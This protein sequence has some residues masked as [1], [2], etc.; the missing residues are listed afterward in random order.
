MPAEIEAFYSNMARRYESSKMYISM[1]Y[2]ARRLGDKGLQTKAIENEAKK[3]SDFGFEDDAKL[4]SN[5]AKKRIEEG[6]LEDIDIPQIEL[7][8]IDVIGKKLIAHYDSA[9]ELFDNA[10]GIKALKHAKKLVSGM[11]SISRLNSLYLDFYSGWPLAFAK[12]LRGMDRY[13]ADYFI[14]RKS[15][16]LEFVCPSI[17]EIA[18]N[19]DLIMEKKISQKAKGI[20]GLLEEYGVGELYEGK[21]VSAI[22]KL[23]RN[24]VGDNDRLL[25]ALYSLRWEDISVMMQNIGGADSS[26]P[27]LLYLALEN[28]ESIAKSGDFRR[29]KGIIESMHDVAMQKTTEPNNFEHLLKISQPMK[30]S[31]SKEDLGRY[32]K[33]RRK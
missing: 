15:D 24:A 6:S 23:V 27:R 20:S 26:K 22:P 25:D 32:V 21:L 9:K 31:R 10:S 18:E 7:S 4:F 29:A 5:L 1:F 8:I 14:E 3:F 16:Y 2:M 19:F 33:L 30:S 12:G 28:L 17:A 13:K 11:C